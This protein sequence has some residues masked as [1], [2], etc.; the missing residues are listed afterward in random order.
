MKFN[1][2]YQSNHSDFKTV[3]LKTSAMQIHFAAVILEQVFSILTFVFALLSVF[4]NRNPNAAT[5]Y[6]RFQ[7]PQYSS[8]TLV[9]LIMCY[10]FL[11]IS[12]LQTD[13]AVQQNDDG[14]IEI[15]ITDSFSDVNYRRH[16]NASNGLELDTVDS[17]DYQ[18]E[19]SLSF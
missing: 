3:T 15:V 9:N 13:M 8:L 12:T 16:S 5:Q 7:I 18:L 19:G 1:S 4:Q 14:T 11:T 17:E 10:I 6:E 2:L